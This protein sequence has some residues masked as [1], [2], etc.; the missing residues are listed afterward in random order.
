MTGETLGV[1]LVC[2]LFEIDLF[3]LI[4][5][6]F[7]NN[8]IWSVFILIFFTITLY[9]EASLKVVAHLHTHKYK[10][11]MDDIILSDVS[12]VSSGPESSP[13]G[14]P[15][16]AC[17][18]QQV[19]QHNTITTSTTTVGGSSVHGQANHRTDINPIH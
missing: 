9:F 18:Q 13:A 1:N 12:S 14:S 8:D 2:G 6:P 10:V 17:S 5:P 16:P 19:I 15:A 4:K 11:R 3:L 7:Y